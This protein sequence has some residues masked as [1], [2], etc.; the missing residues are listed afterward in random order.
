M[1]ESE[2]QTVRANQCWLLLS[3]CP[4]FQCLGQSLFIPYVPTLLLLASLI[5]LRSSPVWMMNCVVT[6]II[7][8]PSVHCTASACS[9]NKALCRFLW[10]LGEWNVSLFWSGSH[11]SER[12]THSFTKCW[13]DQDC[14]CH[15]E[16]KGGEIVSAWWGEDEQPLQRWDDIWERM[17]RSRDSTNRK[18]RKKFSRGIT[19][20]VVFKDREYSC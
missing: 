6:L 9:L 14:E 12:D 4:Y 1:Q 3:R 16:L 15:I 8:P 18:V 7:L 10:Y 17:V 2:G 5:I 13:D 19:I 11:I 20:T